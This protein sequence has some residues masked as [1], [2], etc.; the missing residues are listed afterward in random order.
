[1]DLHELVPQLAELQAWGGIV[2]LACS[3]AAAL[4]PAQR[5]QQPPTD[6]Q[7]QVSAGVSCSLG[8]PASDVF[9]AHAACVTELAGLYVRPVPPVQSQPTC[10]HSDN[11]TLPVPDVEVLIFYLW[12][13]LL[14]VTQDCYQPVTDLFRAL[15]NPHAQ[16]AG[17]CRPLQQQHARE[18]ALSNLLQVCAC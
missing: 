13:Q 4:A 9:L 17:A 8:G 11:S 18:M 5:P 3:K 12:C 1:M 6:Q 16:V 7:R 2:Q 14:I 15:H 10:Y